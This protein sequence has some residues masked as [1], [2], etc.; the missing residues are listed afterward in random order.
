MLRM[1]LFVDSRIREA[2]HLSLQVPAAS[3]SSANL[4]V[5]V[6]AVLQMLITILSI[7]AQLLWAS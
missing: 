7:V 5:G 2:E 4:E 3:R 6:A 1:L